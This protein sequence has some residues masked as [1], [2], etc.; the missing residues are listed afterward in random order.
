M[1]LCVKESQGASYVASLSLCRVI[2][3]TQKITQGHI[4]QQT[5]RH[6]R[7]C[8]QINTHTDRHTTVPAL[9]CRIQTNRVNCQKTWHDLSD[10]LS[11]NRE[12]DWRAFR[13]S[14]P[15][16][17]PAHSVT[18]RA[19]NPPQIITLGGVCTP[20]DRAKKTWLWSWPVLRVLSLLNHPSQGFYYLNN[21]VTIN[22]K[23]VRSSSCLDI[24]KYV[25][26]YTE[27]TGKTLR[28]KM[29]RIPINCHF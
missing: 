5:C 22:W 12:W 26:D 20:Q 21:S 15:S 10:S 17:P 27:S 3:S 11:I 14:A 19:L 8:T 18:P 16:A 4:S 28:N 6:A 9:C 1:C 29:C 7:T 23:W 25:M 2:R 24:S 13:F